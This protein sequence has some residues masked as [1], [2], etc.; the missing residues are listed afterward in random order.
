MATRITREITEHFDNTSIHY[1]LIFHNCKNGN[2]Q[3][4]FLIFFYF[5]SKLRSMFC[6]KEKKNHIFSSENY[7]FIH[8][9]N[10]SL[11]HGLIIYIAEASTM[12]MRKTREINEVSQWKYC[13]INI[14]TCRKLVNPSN[15]Y[16]QSE[17][18]FYG[19]R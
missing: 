6:A 1:T 4:K 13:G 17:T 19:L 5:C 14:F 18:E 2:F 11:L 8:H 10:G 16:I 12:A 15:K 9:L 7:F 3:M